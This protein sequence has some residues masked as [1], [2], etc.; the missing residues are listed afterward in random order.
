[1]VKPIFKWS[2]G[3]GRLIQKYTDLGFF[4]DPSQFD[5]FVDLFFGGGAVTCW[6]ADRYPDKKLIINDKNLELITMYRH[7]VEDW[8]KFMFYY[9][10]TWKTFINTPVDRRKDLFMSYK[11]RYRWNWQNQD[12]VEMSAN[13]LVLMKTNFNGIWLVYKKWGPR[14]GTAPGGVTYK[15]SVFDP[16]LVRQFREVLRRATILSGSFEEVIIPERSWV[17]ADPP[18]RDGT[19]SEQYGIVFGDGHQDKLVKFLQESGAF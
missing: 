12:P 5:T 13:L 7:M 8:D 2:G 18:Y 11:K 1:M 19:H 14:F 15:E 3:K 9:E 4:P 10:R 16:A 17:Y 6:V